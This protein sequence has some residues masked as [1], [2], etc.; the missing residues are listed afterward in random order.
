MCEQPCQGHVVQCGNCQGDGRDPRWPLVA[1][2][3][4]CQGVGS[5]LLQPK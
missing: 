1:E 2:C 3:G 4:T 5:V